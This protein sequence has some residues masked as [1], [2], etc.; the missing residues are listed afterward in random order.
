MF[1]LPNPRPVSAPP[2]ERRRATPSPRTAS[3]A[4]ARGETAGEVAVLEILFSIVRLLVF[5]GR[6]MLDTTSV[7]EDLALEIIPLTLSN[8]V[9]PVSLSCMS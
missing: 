3:P 7:T 4:M 2:A 9:S 6:R 1:S 5:C 8:I